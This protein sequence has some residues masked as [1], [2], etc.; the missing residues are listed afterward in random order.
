MSSNYPFPVFFLTFCPLVAIFFNNTPLQK[1]K[2][3]NKNT[4]KVG[5][6]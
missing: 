1:K 2:P 4:T 5:N 6:S 3:K